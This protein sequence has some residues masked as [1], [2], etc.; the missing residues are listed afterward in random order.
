VLRQDILETAEIVAAPA[1]SQ[2][3]GAPFSHAF[4]P[5]IDVRSR[6]IYAYE[7]LI[8]GVHNEPAFQI[9]ARVQPGELHALDRASRTSARQLA[10]RLGLDCRL[11][12]NVLPRGLDQ[13]ELSTHWTNPTPSDVP[14]D[15]IILEVTEGEVIDDH[16]SF[17][18][19]VNQYRILGAQVAIDDFGAGY[20]GLNLLAEFQPELI[21]LDMNLLRGVESSGPRQSII[22]AIVNVCLDL[23]IDVIAEGVETKDEYLW[24]CDEGVHLFQGYLFARPGFESLPQVMYP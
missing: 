8:R 9:F 15:R 3:P 13:A 21:K 10:A 24:F 22:R 19:L 2:T 20:S 7:A 18:R 17:A 6:R 14:L 11:A 1:G 4:Q 5:I 23:G 16:A 12:L